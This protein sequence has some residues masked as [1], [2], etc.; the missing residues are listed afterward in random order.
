MTNRERAQSIV[1]KL[2]KEA[3][4][5]WCPRAFYDDETDFIERI[6][7]TAVEEEREACAEIVYGQFKAYREGKRPASAIVEAEARIRAR[8]NKSA[9]KRNE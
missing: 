7:T 8:R 6:I 5:A 4:D 2:E 3:A 9:E 1:D